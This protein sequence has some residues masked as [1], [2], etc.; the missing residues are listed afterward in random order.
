MLASDAGSGVNVHGWNAN[1]MRRL[2]PMLCGIKR[3]QFDDGLSIKYIT[4]TVPEM[5][6]EP[7]LGP[8]ERCMR[9][10][11][12]RVGVGVRVNGKSSSSSKNT[13]VCPYIER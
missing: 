2:P 13:A 12:I 7:N 4:H 5:K 9:G 8:Y 6:R 11:N 3:E 10:H 1:R